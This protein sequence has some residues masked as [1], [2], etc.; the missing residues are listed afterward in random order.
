MKVAVTW[1]MCGY[2]DINK[3]TMEECMEYLRNTPTISRSRMGN[4]WTEV[5][6]FH[7]MTLERW[8]QCPSFNSFCHIKAQQIAASFFLRI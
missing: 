5:S 8:K 3:D 6:S 1:T 4:T 7:L 2:I